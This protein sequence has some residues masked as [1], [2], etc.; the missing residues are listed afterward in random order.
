MRLLVSVE[1]LG[2]TGTAALWLAVVAT[3]SAGMQVSITH[4]RRALQ[5]S[6]TQLSVFTPGGPLRGGA[7]MATKAVATPGDGA[8]NAIPL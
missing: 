5:G 6:H 2:D 4:S 3:A 1:W 8:S 7:G